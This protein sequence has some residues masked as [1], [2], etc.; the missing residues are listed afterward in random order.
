[1]KLKELNDQL[2]GKTTDERLEI[3]ASAF[4]GKII[5]TTSF[6][7]EDQVITH[8]IFS[9][10]LDI[11]VV[12]LD[13]GRLFPETYEVYSQTTLKY[14]KKI[15]VYFPD[16][17]SVEELVTEKGPSVFSIPGKTVKSAAK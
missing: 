16:Y 9:N 13:T 12:T 8:K 11:K 7:I 1:M 3:L 15:N 5:F 14:K 17:L 2:A 4:K 6:G 10:N